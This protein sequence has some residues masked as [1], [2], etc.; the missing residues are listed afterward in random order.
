M[1][2]FYH[3]HLQYAFHD[4]ARFRLHKN[5]GSIYSRKELH[6]LLQNPEKMIPL[7]RQQ[8]N[9]WNKHGKHVLLNKKIP[10]DE[11]GKEEGEEVIETKL[12]QGEK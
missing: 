9:K 6:N 4:Q 2:W 5:E 7:P 1:Q 3:L 8:W 11:E 10:T 12:E